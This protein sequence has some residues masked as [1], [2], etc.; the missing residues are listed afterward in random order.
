[1]DVQIAFRGSGEATIAMVIGII[2]APIGDLVP[3]T[4]YNLA[5]AGEDAGVPAKLSVA[6]GRRPSGIDLASSA[7]NS[8]GHLVTQH[9]W[10]RD[11]T[12]QVFVRRVDI[13]P[14][15]IGQEVFAFS[16]LLNASETTIAGI[17]TDFVYCFDGDGL[18]A[19][20]RGVLGRDILA[21]RD[22][23]GMVE[24]TRGSA[25]DRFL[26]LPIWGFASDGVGLSC[27][28][29]RGVCAI[30]DRCNALWLREDRSEAEEVEFSKLSEMLR[31]H[32]LGWSYLNDGD[33]ARAIRRYNEIHPHLLAESSS[34]PL[35]AEQFHE[36][37]GAMA[38][39]VAETY[40]PG[41][42]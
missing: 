28:M 36:R 35:T 7:A 40:S 22:A 30:L 19:E 39:A 27:T 5:V 11:S 38:Q 14:R 16:G 34:L 26:K 4:I 24:K 32:G 9:M 20:L 29:E 31:P 8:L 13:A 33:F 41:Y 21:G 6:N 12:L 10:S 15:E 23:T 18:S 37:D 17:N 3:E 1:M 42:S 25:L 2:A